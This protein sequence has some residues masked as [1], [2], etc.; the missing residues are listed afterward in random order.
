M[1]GNPPADSLNERVARAIR[2]EMGAQRL[3]GVKLARRLNWN[4]TFLSRRTTGQQDLTL[5]EL[6]QIAQQ[7]DVSIERLVLS[8]PSPR[9][10]AS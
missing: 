5:N 3:S 6:E 2:S 1:A 9:R 8:E 4:Q 10:R 7:L